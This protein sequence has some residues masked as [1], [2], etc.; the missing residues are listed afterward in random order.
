M[1]TILITG[2][3][4]G[5][6]YALARAALEKGWTVYGSARSTTAEGQAELRAHANFRALAF[7]VTD[8]A[9]VRAA[10]ASV[11]APIDILVNNAGV[12]G[13][14]APVPTATDLDDFLQ[15]LAVNTVAPLRMV[16]AFL[17]H[18]K[19]SAH[20]RV[21][22]ISSFMGTLSVAHVNSISYRVSKAGVNKVMQG[23]G[24]ELAEA[25]IA[26]ATVSPGWVRTDMGGDN[27]AV[28]P[29]DSASGILKIAEELTLAT[30]GRF[31]NYDGAALAW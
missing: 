20:A 31:L 5:I 28:A 2:T 4:R 15:T 22:T 8:D 13:D 23:L 21:L 25:G 27:A 12:I 3:G 7:D 24:I 17:P 6:G 29:E 11:D 9:A 1:T 10:A 26:V 30:T 16:R 14:R 19:R 18:L